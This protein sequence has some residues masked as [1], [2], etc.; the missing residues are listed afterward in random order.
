MKNYFTQILNNEMNKGVTFKIR[1][2]WTTFLNRFL[3][4]FRYE[5]ANNEQWTHEIYCETLIFPI[6]K[7]WSFKM[8]YLIKYY[9]YKELGFGSRDILKY[10]YVIVIQGVWN[11][12]TMISWKTRERFICADYVHHHNFCEPIFFI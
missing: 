10:D 11:F 1:N 2:N 9:P 7:D 8:L 5:L 3:I 4:S 6:D 12:I